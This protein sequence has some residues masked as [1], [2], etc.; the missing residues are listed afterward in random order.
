MAKLPPETP[1]ASLSFAIARNTARMYLRKHS[2]KICVPDEISEDIVS[3]DN[4]EERLLRN[5]ENKLIYQ[6]LKNI[7]PEAGQVIYLSYFENLSNEETAVIMKKK[8][9]QIETL[10]YNAKKALKINL[11]RSG[12]EY[13][14]P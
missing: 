1:V 11:E 10:L 4:V 9:R 2:V 7:K 14:K 3:S 13:G 5:E 6:S 12:F 8:R